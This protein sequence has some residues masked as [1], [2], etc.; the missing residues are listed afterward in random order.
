VKSPTPPRG[1]LATERENEATRALDALPTEEALRVIGQQDARVHAAL[2]AARP[3]LAR[4]VD[5]VAERLS[6]GGRLFYV[7][8]G[9]SGR[10]AALDAAEL[11]PTFQSD[12]AQVQAILAGGREA[13]WKAVEGAEDDRDAA[14]AELAAR[15]LCARDAVLAIA[16][17]GTTPF[18]HGA[19]AA[20][21]A[22]GALSIFLACVPFDEAPDE[23]EISIRVVPGPEVVTGST[24]LA[25]GTATK[26]ALNALSTLVMARL[27]KL[28]GNLMVDVDTKAN[29]KL[30][31]RGARIVATLTGLDRAAALALLERADGHVK[32]AVVMQ[33]L[34]LDAPAA[35]A[36]LERAGGHLRRALEPR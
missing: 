4:A 23:A 31:E 3:A 6:R 18:A 33:R 9:T 7:G 34:S 14:G 2:E 28:H 26:L 10:L 24:R 8:A 36:R 1:H 19:L 17:G 29:A 20:A 30:V 11:P 21:R 25:A 5:A 27:G 16:A 13:M 12:P 35:R 22:R 32:T 15:G